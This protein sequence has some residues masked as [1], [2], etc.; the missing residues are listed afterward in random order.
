MARELTRRDFVAE[1]VLASAGAVVGAGLLRADDSRP[2]AANPPAAAS[3][4][5]TAKI[6]NL[7]L[8]RLMLG[9]NLLN[10]CAHSRDLRYVSQLMCRYNT[11]EKILETLALAEKHGI[12]SINMHIEQDAANKIVKE[13]RRRGGKIKWIMAVYAI[14]M[15]SNPFENIERAARE[16]ADALYIW[17][18]AADGLVRQKNIDLM[19]RTLEQMRKTGLPCGIAAHTPAVIVAAE[20]AKLDCDFYQK[21]LHTNNYPT[22]QKP[23]EPGDYGSYDNSWCRNAE[24][25]VGIM[26][27]IKKPWIAFKVMA[28]GA[29]PP[30]EA[31]PHAFNNGADF[32]LA[33][34]FDFQVAEDVQIA[35]EALAKANRQRP[36]M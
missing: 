26:R 15:L 31:F 9:G 13:Y 24:Q 16:G 17:G 2:A 8:S 19:K 23:D 20:K 22:A 35:K 6:G 3:P 10:G 33:G 21:T 5:W 36:W 12:N 30:R 18:A 1:S 34:M 29:I 32:V 7:E 11:D 4:G 25:V 28:A 27:E 14:P